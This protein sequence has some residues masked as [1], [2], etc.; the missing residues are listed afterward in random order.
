MSRAALVVLDFDG[1]VCD[2]LVECAAVTAVG[3]QSEGPLPGLDEAVRALTD[4]YVATFASARPYCRTLDDFMVA[5]VLEGP[6]GS[7]ADFEA[8]RRSID[9]RE[10][11]RQAAR[12]QQARDSW[13]RADRRRWL[14]LHTPYDGVDRLVR[15]AS[16]RV[17]IVTAK[18]APSVRRLLEHF[19]LHDHVRDVVGGCADKQAALASLVGDCGTAAF[20]D[21]NLAN[22]LAV[23]RVPGVRS[24]WATWGH[25]SAEDVELARARHVT[26]LDL[27]QL[28][29]VA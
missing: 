8:A 22:V 9:A 11:R 16:G 27:G 15:A 17:V 19:G 26:A 2:A 5:N 13:R 20:V 25:H 21:D 24:L 1:V 14:D 7:R 29:D 12:A 23:A 4:A 3:G 28:R 10:V 18:D 6:V